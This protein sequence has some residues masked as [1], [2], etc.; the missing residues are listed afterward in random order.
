MPTN[1]HFIQAAKLLTPGASYSADLVL[2]HIRD[3]AGIAQRVTVSNFGEVSISYEG[4]DV[5]GD[6]LNFPA[7]A[8]IYAPASPGHDRSAPSE[9]D[10]AVAVA[11]LLDEVVAEF[12]LERTAAAAWAYREQN[13]LPVS[14]AALLTDLL[15]EGRGVNISLPAPGARLRMRRDGSMVIGLRISR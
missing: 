4:Q 8:Y 15:G 12:G 5:R 10:S 6:T 3:L 14:V 11:L 7:L 9:I 13:E 1:A 2:P